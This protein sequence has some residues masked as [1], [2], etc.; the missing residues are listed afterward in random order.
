LFEVDVALQ[1]DKQQGPAWSVARGLSA[2]K[3][4]LDTSSAFLPFFFFSFF[5]QIHA[6]HSVCLI[7]ADAK[8]LLLAA[9]CAGAGW[10]YDGLLCVAGPGEGGIWECPVGGH[11]LDMINV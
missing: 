10:E 5:S 8:L 3:L 1:S 2:V 4:G 7:V 11:T 9:C 6:G